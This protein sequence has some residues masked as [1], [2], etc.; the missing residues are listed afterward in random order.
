MVVSGCWIYSAKSLHSYYNGQ[1]KYKNIIAIDYIKLFQIGSS[2]F[3]F[4]I[5][6]GVRQNLAITCSIESVVSYTSGELPPYRLYYRKDCFLYRIQGNILSEFMWESSIKETLLI[7]LRRKLH[8]IKKIVYYFESVWQR[9]YAHSIIIL[10]Q[11]IYS[12]TII[13][14]LT[15]R[16]IFRM[17][18]ANHVPKI[19]MQIG[20][21]PLQMPVWSPQATARVVEHAGTTWNCLKFCIRRYSRK[22]TSSDYFD[23][24]T[25][26]LHKLRI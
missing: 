10:K 21:I 6:V 16:Q 2:W 1:S 12:L 23:K 25:K 7:Q 14:L 17:F 4:R 24:I 15:S 20:S 22:L 13:A 19:P 26:V 8:S 5:F 3:L 18:I 9:T 11:R